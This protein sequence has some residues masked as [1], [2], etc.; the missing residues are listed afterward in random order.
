MNSSYVK[1]TVQEDEGEYKGG[2]YGSGDLTGSDPHE[3]YDYAIVVTKDERSSAQLKAISARCAA[4]GIETAP[5]FESVQQD[6]LYLLVR[7]GLETL[8]V[9][10]MPPSVAGECLK[11][12]AFRLSRS[13]RSPHPRDRPVTNFSPS[14][15]RPPRHQFTRVGGLA[16]FAVRVTV[17]WC[18]AGVR[19]SFR[20]SPCLAFRWRPREPTPLSRPRA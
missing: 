13:R 3:E 16:P 14:T 4:A 18:V 1:V 2:G 10:I 11:R 19:S 5:I 8:E 9:S 15:P 17:V 20:A 12:P 7:V 6:E